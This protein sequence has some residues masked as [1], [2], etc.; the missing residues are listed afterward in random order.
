MATINAKK[1]VLAIVPEV[2]QGTPVAPTAANQYLALRDDS[3]IDPAFDTL[4]NAEL[5]NSIGKA[6][7]IISSENP[8]FSYNHY[9]RHSGVEGQAPNYRELLKGFFGAERVRAL[10]RDTIAGSTTTVLKMD[11]G[12]G[13][14]FQKGDIVLIKNSA[15]Y[16]I[17][18]VESVAGDDLTLNFAINNA[19]G[20][21]V[22]TG[23]GVSYSAANDSHQSVSVWHYIGNGGATQLLAGG[24]VTTF[25]FEATAKELIDASFSVEGLGFYR[26]AIEVTATNKFVD[27][28]DGAVQV[29]SIAEKMYKTPHELASA[30]Q[31]AMD[32]QSTDTIT[33]TYSDKTGKFTFAT[34]GVVLSLLWNTGANKANSIG[35]T[36]GFL[37]AADDTGA[38]SYEGDNAVS[39]AAPQTPAY[40]AAD[41]IAAKNHQVMLGTQTDNGCF[42]A[43]VVS[44]TGALTK[45]ANG[46]LCAE[47]GQGE[48][49]INE[50]EVTVSVSALLDQNEVG[51]FEKFR[52]GDEVRFQ[53]SFGN[54]SGGN[55]IAGK[56][57]AFYISSAT[58]TAYKIVNADGLAQLDATITGFIN[59]SAD[60]EVHLGFV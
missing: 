28:N 59:A 25:D 6:K 33:V 50:R 30:L 39:W 10:E 1:S 5:R 55:W 51:Y 18:F 16:E 14:E 57:G 47:S 56:S 31:T 38:T 46:D 9:L 44:F 29:A 26:N 53:Y 13:A 23:L 32:L 41:P 35:S 54:K 7:P 40:D 49:I 60:A 22:N 21:G 17:R 15:G 43:S 42:H 48:S 24:L 8:S 3:E 36:L 2:T 45:S 12:E 20:T 37:V 27:F 11:V 4:E 19:P 58:I 52:N 34:D